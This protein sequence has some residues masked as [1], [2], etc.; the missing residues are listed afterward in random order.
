MSNSNLVA[1]LNANY[2]NGYPSGD[3][4]LRNG[5][6]PLISNWNTGNYHIVASGL[7]DTTLTPTGIVFAGNTGDL[8]SDPLFIY[9]NN[10]LRVAQIAQCTFVGGVNF[11]FNTLSNAVIAESDIVTSDITLSSGNTLNASNGTVIFSKNQIPGYAVSGGTANV[12]ISGTSALVVNGVYTTDY[13]LNISIL[14]ADSAGQPTRLQ[15]PE[16]SFVGRLPGGL[17]QAISVDDMALIGN[18]ATVGDSGGNSGGSFGW[19]DNKRTYSAAITKFVK[20]DFCIQRHFA[21]KWSVV[22][23]RSLVQEITRE[24]Q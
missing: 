21:A 1:N 2:L 17:I 13:S 8:S 11:N 4:I 16:N 7:S 14:K 24:E 19:R 22:E 9:E 20:C 23:G 18:I 15:I 6:V 12:D 3:F 10:T 5:S